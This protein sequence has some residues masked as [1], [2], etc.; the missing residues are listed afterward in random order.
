MS[1]P[2]FNI[3]L[4]IMIGIYI[5]FAFQKGKKQ[6]FMKSTLLKTTLLAIVLVGVTSCKNS[7]KETELEIEAPAEASETA[8]EYIVDTAASQILWEGSK[9]GTIHHGTVGLSSGVLLVNE[10]EL[11][12]GNFVIDM[13]TITD[14]DLEGEY[15][16]NL[17]A[18]L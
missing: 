10:G 7:G 18:H 3:T 4:R 16:T 12:A 6:Y 15:K 9:P 11:E 13:N 1:R 8:S 2:E 5:T 14:E 17:E